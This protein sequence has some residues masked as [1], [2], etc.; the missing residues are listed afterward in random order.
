MPI[1]TV[2][3]DIGGVLIEWD[4]RHLYRTMFDDD[5]A[6]EHFL[7]T[8]C[9]PAWNAELDRGRPFAEAVA[10]LAAAHPE[11][12][13]AIAAYH[14]RWDE[15]VPGAL[16]ESVAVFA[17]LRERRVACY[18]L[19]NFSREKFDRVRRRYPLLEWF[20][21]IVVSADERVVKPEPEIFTV[22]C[23]RFGVVPR[24]SVFVD[25]NPDNTRAARAL[26]FETVDFRSAGQLREAL[27]A[28]G[29][30]DER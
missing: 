25:D 2:V 29:L 17:E 19:T 20:D 21:G 18:G 13:G 28:H 3:L 7:A 23:E 14:E 24:R 15:M 10:E 4:P 6:M 8:V 30:L 27:V 12:A 11:H 9:T 1:D 22:L 26:G 5:E 16:D